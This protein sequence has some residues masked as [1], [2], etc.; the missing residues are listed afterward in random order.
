MHKKIIIAPVNSET[1][2]RVLFAPIREFPTE[3]MVFLAYP[4]GMARAEA[5]REELAKLGIPA[6]L[7]K[8]ARGE[9]T[10]EDFFSA[11]AAAL[12]GQEPGRM[13]INIASADRV[14]QCALTNVAHVNGVRAVAVIGGQLIMLPILK[15]SFGSVLS[16][17][18]MRV[19]KELMKNKCFLSI[20]D[21]AKAAGLSVQLA[22]YHVHG[23]P[24]SPGLSSLELVE[25]EE[26]KGRTKVCLS[27]MGR[28]LMKGHIG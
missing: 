12:E 23:T 10:W 4:E 25:V 20:E 15:L 28:L 17:K 8:V 19:L 7:A 9:N 22:S 13:L 16:E 26:G 24:K 14:S 18:K 2:S 21:L 27:P 11:G 3:R 6:S 1:D 5:L